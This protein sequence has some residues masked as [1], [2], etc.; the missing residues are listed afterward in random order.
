MFSLP[1][2]SSIFPTQNIDKTCRPVLQRAVS[3]KHSQ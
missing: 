1:Q 3:I 2:S